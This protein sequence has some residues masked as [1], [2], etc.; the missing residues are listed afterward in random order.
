M[1]RRGPEVPPRAHAPEPCPPAADDASPRASE[2]LFIS[3]LHL[4][5]EQPQLTALFLDWLR[6]RAAGAAAVYILGDL[7]DAWIGDDDDTY[8]DIETGLA[9]LTAAGT[10]CFVMHGNRDFL[11]GRRF[12]RRTGCTL[13]RDPARISLDGEPVLLMHGDLLC[14]DDVA[15]QRFRR[16]VRNPLVQWLFLRQPLHKRRGIAAGYRRRSAAAMAAKSDAIM[17]VNAEAVRRR[18]QRHGVRRLIHGHT[19]RP[20]DHRLDLDGAPVLRHVLADWSP[21]G[22]E[23][24]VAAGGGIAREAVRPGAVTPKPGG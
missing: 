17:D 19:H 21:Q 13:L 16:R 7:F 18:M 11:L 20:A 10:P 3:D 1:D 15:Y 24:L 6:T 23:A 14:T 2:R 12:A 8:A 5:P 4:S 9:A 22:G